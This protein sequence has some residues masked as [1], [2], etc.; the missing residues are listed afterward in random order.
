MPVYMYRKSRFVY[1]SYFR[2]LLYSAFW[3][4]DMTR[5]E[6]KIA[7]ERLE[8]IVADLQSAAMGEDSD[9]GLIITL[10]YKLAMVAEILKQVLKDSA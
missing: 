2:T 5:Q 1:M 7:I 8:G 3:P 10:T 4:A 6:R 9:M